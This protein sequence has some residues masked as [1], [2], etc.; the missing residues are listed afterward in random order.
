MTAEVIRDMQNAGDPDVP[1]TEVVKLDLLREQ[2]FGSFERTPWAPKLLSLGDRKIPG[3]ENPGFKPKETPESIAERADTFLSTYLLPILADPPSSAAAV[4]IV[5]HGV[6][7]AVLW[8][9]WLALFGRKA[10]SFDPRI[11]IRS[12]S[13][14][15]ELLPVWSNTGYLELHARKP[16]IGEKVAPDS[17]PKI[18]SSVSPAAPRG[19][20]MVI[21][22][23]NCTDHLVNLKRA[24]GGLGSARFDKKQKKLEGFFKRA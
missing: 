13:R 20:K 18:P 19:W 1:H 5:A 15:L 6:I 12:T 8:R 7:L 24:R 11:R 16:A 4:A 17:G 21:I 22:Q 3:P 23:I 2:D 10:F 14:P 9:R